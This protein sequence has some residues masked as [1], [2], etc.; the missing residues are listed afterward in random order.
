MCNQEK[1]TRNLRSRVFIS[2]PV[3]YHDCSINYLKNTSLR[4]NVSIRMF[5]NEKVVCICVVIYILRRATMYIWLLGDQESTC[6]FT[7]SIT[8]YMWV[9]GDQEST[10]PF[11]VSITI[12][13]LGIHINYLPTCRKEVLTIHR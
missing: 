4:I 9:L 7:V 3:T 12:L 11:T 8:M 2:E 1:R 13:R 5:N 10:F 6:P